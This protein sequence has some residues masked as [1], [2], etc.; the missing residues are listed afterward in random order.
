MAIQAPTDHLVKTM[1]ARRS[2]RRGRPRAFHLT[3][4]DREMRHLDQ[5]AEPYE[6]RFAHALLATSPQGRQ[7][8]HYPDVLAVLSDG[9]RVAY[10]LELSQKSRRWL[11]QIFI[12]YSLDHRL[13]S[14]VYVTN[15]RQVANALNQGAAT[16]GLGDLI[17]VR[18]FDRRPAP[19][20][21]SD[22][23]RQAVR[24]VP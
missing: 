15:R 24:E 2:R 23:P 12:A 13:R 1:Q 18:Y 5:Q 8:G 19:E 10:E 6:D 20:F 3:E 9:S 11:E 14:V 7:R 22:W 4:P 16:F 17:A 21:W